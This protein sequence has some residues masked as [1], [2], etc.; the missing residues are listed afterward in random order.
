MRLIFVYGPPAS[1]KLTV[2]TELAKLTGFRLF[3]NHVSIRFMTSLFPFGSRTFL[4]L[5]DKYRREMIE[6]AA[7][8]RISVIFTYV[9]GKGVDDEFVRDVVR[10]VKRHKG[11]VHF[12]RLFCN[13]EELARRVGSPGRR[14]LGKLT[15]KR[16]LADLYRIFD[17]EAEIPSQTSLR[18][19]TG[20]LRPGQAA[21]MILRHYKL[22]VSKSRA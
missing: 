16:T 8:E 19:D 10:R 4:R 5:L 9:Y 1:G 17:M 20:K 13:R 11:Q 15:K 21:Q 7:R 6:E 3:D 2:A 22:P 14:A 18:I 12:V